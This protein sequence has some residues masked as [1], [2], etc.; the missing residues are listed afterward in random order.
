MKRLWYG[1]PTAQTHDILFV[2]F[3]NMTNTTD[4]Q[5]RVPVFVEVSVPHYHPGPYEDVSGYSMKRPVSQ[6][7][8]WVA[9]EKKE[10]DGSAVSVIMPPREKGFFEWTL[11]EW[12]R[13]FKSTPPVFEGA[14]HIVKLRHLHINPQKAAEM[15]LVEG[16]LVSIEKTDGPRPGRLDGIV[17]RVTPW[18][19]L[20]VHLDTDE[21]NALFIDRKG[22]TLTMIYSHNAD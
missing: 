9:N 12:Q 3:K 2:R 16:Q 5:R 8:H 22:E 15:G 17:V 18:G 14:E 4:E 20:N 11:T 6:D 7:N 13:H 19:V 10:F 1:K 21:A